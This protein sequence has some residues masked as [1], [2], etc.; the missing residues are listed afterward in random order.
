MD[1][2]ADFAQEGFLEIHWDYYRVKAGAGAA[3][4]FTG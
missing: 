2:F 1:G 4:D 3:L